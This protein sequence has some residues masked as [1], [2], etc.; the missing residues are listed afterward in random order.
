MKHDTEGV[1]DEHSSFPSCSRGGPPLSNSSSSCTSICGYD[2]EEGKD[3]ERGGIQIVGISPARHEVR[4]HPQVN[5]TVVASSRGVLQL[6]DSIVAAN[7]GFAERQSLD[8]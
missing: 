1:Y 5:Q 7:F 2:N 6:F 8:Q 4:G 3:G